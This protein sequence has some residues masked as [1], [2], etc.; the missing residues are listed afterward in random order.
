MT[1]EGLGKDK[2]AK[3]FFF[4]V[5]TSHCSES[6]CISVSYTGIFKLEMHFRIH[7]PNLYL[8]IL[9]K[10]EYCIGAHQDASVQIQIN[11]I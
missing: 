3:S 5:L 1:S 4:F 2:L 10:A 8:D 7:S 9:E 6:N 11:E